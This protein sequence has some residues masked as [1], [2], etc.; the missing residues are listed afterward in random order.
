M[1]ERNDINKYREKQKKK[2]FAAK[3][4]VFMTIIIIVILVAANWQTLIAPLKDAA[5]DLGSGG[6][7][8]MLPGSTEYNLGT[9]GENFYL[10]T[11]T[12]LYTYTSAGAE[13][14]SAQH[15]FQD[16]A[17]SANDNRALIYDKNG[18][19][20]KVFSRTKEMF[21]VNTDDNIIFAS[22]GNGERSAVITAST[23]YSNLLYIFNAEGRQIFRWASPDE[24][25]MGVCFSSDDNSIFV[26]VVGEHNG[27]FDSYILRFDITD[28]E[29]KS[30][31]W[32][33][34]LGEDIT[35]SLQM[36]FDG[37]YAVTASGAYLLNEK[38]GEINA[39]N[40]FYDEVTGIPK[41]DSGLRCVIFRDPASNGAVVTSYNGKLE[42]SSTAKLDGVTD[43]DVNGGKLFILNG[44]RLIVYNSYLEGAKVYKLDDEY[45][46]VK[47]IG[48]SAYLLG[49]NTVQRVNL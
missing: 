3:S 21:S 36:C 5:L 10:L 23:R 39:S 43:F 45:S 26:S 24:K 20:F 29:A 17:C 35:Y 48:G 40:T 34:S 44:N 19:T 47:I 37:I 13:I 32:R 1:D 27:T 6:F 12:Y 41:S 7:P 18:R 9:L 14:M 31:V 49:Y 38:T 30:E 46:K 22:M 8:V 25:I 28:A 15:G 2:K 11:D 42:A 16:P 4:A 33:T